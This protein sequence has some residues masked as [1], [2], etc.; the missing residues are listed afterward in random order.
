M[1]FGVD[2]PKFYRR[3]CLKTMAI[4]KKMFENNGHMHAHVYSPGAGADNR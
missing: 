2:W 1:K 3:K 4:E